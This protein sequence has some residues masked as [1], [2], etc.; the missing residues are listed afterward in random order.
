[1]P[2]YPIFA[3]CPVCQREF[4]LEMDICDRCH[5]KGSDGRRTGQRLFISEPLDTD[6]QF[7]KIH[8]PGSLNKGQIASMRRRNGNI[9]PWEPRTPGN[10]TF[11]TRKYEPDD[12]A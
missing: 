4:G 6:G 12:A 1:M 9:V 11:V 3:F 8:M 10:Q 7:R 5:A 2:R